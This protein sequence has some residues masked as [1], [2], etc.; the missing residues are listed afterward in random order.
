MKQTTPADLEAAALEVMADKGKA[1]AL[2]QACLGLQQLIVQQAALLML[3]QTALEARTRT[4][5]IRYEQPPAA[6]ARIEP[7]SL[8]MP[9]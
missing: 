6:P 1:L 9:N 4:Y 2:L 8:F 3:A 7:F 5:T